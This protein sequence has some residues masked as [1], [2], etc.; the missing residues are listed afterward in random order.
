MQLN[1]HLKALLEIEQTAPP[2]D[3]TLIERSAFYG[4]QKKRLATYCRNLGLNGVREALDN[5]KSFRA[6]SRP[7]RFGLADASTVKMD[8]STAGSL[9]TIQGYL[10]AADE[11]PAPERSFPRPVHAGYGASHPALLRSAVFTDTCREERVFKA[12]GFVGTTI[13][14]TGEPLNLDDMHA[15]V[16]A[17]SKLKNWNS[18][19]TTIAVDA[20]EAV[21]TLGWAKNT[22]SVR[23]LL[24]C[25][26]RMQMTRI[27]I[28]DQATGSGESSQ[29]VGKVTYAAD[30]R[31][32]WMV[33]LNSTLLD[34]IA[35]R[36]PTFLKLEAL[37]ALPGG[38]PTWLYGF[39]CSEA[40][41]FT[42]WDEDEL[43]AMAG[44]TSSN[45][46]KRREKLKCALD[47]MVAGVVEV[48]ARG[49]GVHN[50]H[51]GEL[52]E[53]KDGRIVLRSTASKLKTFEPVLVGFRFVKTKGGKS[54]VELHKAMKK[55]E[56]AEV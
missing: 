25:F 3:A 27:R 53:N 36:Y 14:R 20:W 13:E 45:K 39:I 34:A 24:A 15:L 6:L 26:E 40:R 18:E 9:V 19:G 56:A 22:Q 42:T 33:H 11:T 10:E 43:T 46:Y 1:S 54:R 12:L 32:K 48:K 52:T 8:A 30:R 2:P 50:E 29:I 23:R 41:E 21:V 16:Y 31:T 55:N 37:A 49:R 17:I 4:A 5:L 35:D 51:R 7:P 44:L 28:E 38:A 47:T